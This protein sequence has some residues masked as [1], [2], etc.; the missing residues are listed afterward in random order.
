M[1]AL[2]RCFVGNEKGAPSRRAA[3]LLLEIRVN[4]DAK[5]TLTRAIR[6]PQFSTSDKSSSF[7]WCFSRYNKILSLYNYQICNISTSQKL[8]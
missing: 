4:I 1:R 6:E 7:C 3:H 2:E 5:V 8:G